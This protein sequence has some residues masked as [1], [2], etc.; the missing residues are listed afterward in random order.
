MLALGKWALER[1]YSVMEL[2]R[3][4][5]PESSMMKPRHQR[6]LPPETL[7]L[8]KTTRTAPQGIQILLQKTTLMMKLR[9]IQILLLKMMLTT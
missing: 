7:H 8:Q 6:T 4:E 5:V 1:C 9:G 2:A 3:K